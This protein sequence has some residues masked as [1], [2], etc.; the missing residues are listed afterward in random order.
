MD[1]KNIYNLLKDIKKD[2]FSE[3]ASLINKAFLRIPFIWHG[4]C[5]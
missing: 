3:E 1:N 5:N 4:N 2:G